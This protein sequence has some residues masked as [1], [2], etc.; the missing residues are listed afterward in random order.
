MKLLQRLQI[1]AEALP[2]GS[3]VNIPADWLL[4]ELAGE[5]LEVSQSTPSHAASDLTVEQVAQR[6][7]RGP[8]TVR[9]WLAEGAFPNAFKLRGKSWL[10][11][12]S[13]V[14][15]FLDR[16]RPQMAQ[17]ERSSTRTAEGSDDLGSWRQHRRGAA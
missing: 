9:A 16:Q 7:D 6:M 1:M 4:H 13:D 14:T 12:L 5:T 2:P 8:R 3:T 10:I 11:P 17:A 15:A